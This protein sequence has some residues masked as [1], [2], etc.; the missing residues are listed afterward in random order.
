MEIYLS[1]KIFNINITIYER[2]TE[3]EDFTQNALFSQESGTEETII[4]N[5]ENLFHYNLIRI[6]NTIQ[7]NSKLKYI[8]EFNKSEILK[9]NT[10]ITKNEMYHFNEDEYKLNNGKYIE[11]G[12]N[13]NYYDEIYT[14]LQTKEKAKFKNKDGEIFIKWEQVKYPENLI[15]DTMSENKKDK[16]RYNFRQKFRKY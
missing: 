13:K 15:N 5:F 7:N 10:N 2:N 6:K 9:E 1:V 16:K 4:V 8:E 12:D 11:I 3:L 14:F